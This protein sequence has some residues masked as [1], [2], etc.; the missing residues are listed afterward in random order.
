MTSDD[1][2]AFAL[3]HICGRLRGQPWRTTMPA[4]CY[5]LGCGDWAVASQA[6]RSLVGSGL[7]G[8]YRW[9]A[10]GGYPS[11]VPVNGAELDAVIFHGQF[12]VVASPRACAL[13]QQ[14]C[15]QPASAPGQQP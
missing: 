2:Q 11:R 7:A 12:L 1:I 9:I 6:L 15:A 5:T 4:F 13:F 14:A 10:D 3:I 8:V